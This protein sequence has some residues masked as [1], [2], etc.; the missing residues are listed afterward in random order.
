MSAPTSRSPKQASTFIQQPRLDYRICAVLLLASTTLSALAI[1]HLRYQTRVPMRD[2]KSLACDYYLPASAGSWP[3][4]LIQT[5]YSKD[6]KF[7]LILEY[8]I[9]NDPLLKNPDY[10]FAIVDWR[11]FF[12]SNDA[13]YPG[14]PT[15][16]EDGYDTI[17]WI[18]DQP[19][20]DGNV[21]TWGASALGN[22][23]MLTAEQQPPHLKGCVP[24]V[25]EYRQWYDN[26]YPGGVYAR[27][28]NDFIYTKFGGQGVVRQNPLYNAIWAFTEQGIQHPELI[29]VPMLHISGWYDHETLQTVREM[30]TL[31]CGSDPLGHGQHKL[32][33]GPWSHSSVGSKD[34]GQLSY[35]AAEYA[36]S[37]AAVE[38]F[39]HILRGIENGY[40]TQP[41]VRYFSMNEDLWRG[42][43]T[44][45]PTTTAL[46]DYY[47]SA[48][49]SLT[50]QPGMVDAYYEYLSDP[51]HPVP[52]VWGAVIGD[53]TAEQG[54]GDLQAIEARADVLTF[55]TP[56]L[57]QPLTLAGNPVAKLW[58]ECDQVDTD[59]IVRMTEVYPDGRSMLLVDAARR[60]SI[61]E[62][63]RSREELVW[64]TVYPVTVELP[65]VAVS[66]PAGHA[67]RINIGPSSFKRFDINMQDGSDLSDDP[68]ALATLATVR[69]HVG[70]T[71]PS[72]LRLPLA[73][74]RLRA[75]FDEDGLPDI[76]DFDALAECLLGPARYCPDTHCLQDQI[77]RSDFDFDGD[78]DV[79]DFAEFQVEYI[80]ASEHPS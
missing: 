44:W 62:D 4:V 22:A 1:V 2:G 48:Q 39:D 64:G 46:I 70:Q 59:V 25:Y 77:Y 30:Q 52:T 31:W 18:A 74:I 13:A 11:G 19:W 60:V 8:E 61:S 20:C 26:A 34:Q 38:F 49:G 7:P 16:G 5:P 65:P 28:R 21:G 57:D 47:L 10:A 79:V 67:L 17:E 78:A 41:T 51:N 53:S 50:Q 24:I 66:I 32:L 73:D 63:F 56:V 29:S 42:A 14:S 33:I 40:P 43:A 55:T 23:Q 69:L 80:S 3:V 54:P 37:Y 72:R 45:P 35:P 71:Y 76:G 68:N 9:A 12:D 27:S 58:V 15:R 75:D 36:S 6:L